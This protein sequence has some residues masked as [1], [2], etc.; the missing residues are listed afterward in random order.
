MAKRGRKPAA[1]DYKK[2]FEQAQKELEG[3]KKALVQAERNLAK[4]KQR[5]DELVA[6]T[7]RLDMVERS[8]KALIEGTEPPTNVRYVYNYPAW[9]WQ[10]PTITMPFTSPQYGTG[11]TITCQNSNLTGV[12]NSGTFTAGGGLLTNTSVCNSLGAAGLDGSTGS[13]SIVLSSSPEIASSTFNMVDLSTFALAGEEPE[14]QE[15]ASSV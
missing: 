1:T 15:A 3:K 12:A 4:A 6:E 10:S 13:G 14:P 7:A 9:V 2:I 11:Y 8:L 5:H